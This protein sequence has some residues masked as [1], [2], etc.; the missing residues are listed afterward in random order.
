[1]SRRLLA[2]ESRECHPGGASLGA[3]LRPHM[4]DGEWAMSS[5]A[6]L[7]GLPAASRQGRLL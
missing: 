5:V 7:G 1:M 4:A 6:S 2:Q 3:S